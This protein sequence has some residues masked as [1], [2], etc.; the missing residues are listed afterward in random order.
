MVFIQKAFLFLL[1]VGCALISSINSQQTYSF[2]VNLNYCQDQSNETTKASFESNRTVLLSSLSSKASENNSFYNDTSN[3]VYG[4][5]LCRGDASIGT[6]QRCVIYAVE[7]IK[8]LC[9]SSKTVIIWFDDCMLRY[10]DTNFFGVQQIFPGAFMWNIKNTTSPGTNFGAIALM[11][12]LI[13]DALGTE[14]LY[15]TG[16]R[17]VGDGSEWYSHSLLGTFMKYLIRSIISTGSGFPFETLPSLVIADDMNDE[18]DDT[19][20]FVKSSSVVFGFEA[21]TLGSEKTGVKLCGCALMSSIN[22]KPTYNYHFCEDQSNNSSDASFESNLTDLLGSLPSKACQNISFYNDTSNGIYGLFLCRGDVNSSTCQSCVSYA[23]Q[24]IT[25]RCPSN[26]T[27]IIW[28]DEC[29]LRYSNTDFF[30]VEDL[31][32]M[33]FMWNVENLTSPQQTDFGGRALMNG[34]IDDALGT[35]MLYMYKACNSSGQVRYGMVQCTRDINSTSCGN[36]FQQLIT[37]A[38]RRCQKKIGWR[39]LAPSCN[40]RYENYPFIQQPPVPPP[41]PPLPHPVA[42]APQPLP[43]NGKTSSTFPASA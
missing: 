26:T 14:T 30:G 37:E 38:N 5:F 13:A 29:M 9:P 12:E 40:I 17:P 24:D 35:E 3:G 41:A 39:V 22:S 16:K 33:V 43:D 36:C 11:N 32:P 4:L 28:F 18:F 2:P 42:A 7:Y 27:A 6:C 8:L 23:A 31:S 34:L 20:S 25:S 21:K 10:S 15:K 1:F 19:L